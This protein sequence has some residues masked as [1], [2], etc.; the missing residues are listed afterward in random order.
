MD[1]KID[2]VRVLVRDETVALVVIDFVLDVVASNDEGSAEAEK[3]V[4]A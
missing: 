1:E 3:I 2:K 4:T